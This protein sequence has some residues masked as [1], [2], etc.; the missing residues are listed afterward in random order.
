MHLTQ[1]GVLGMWKRFL[2]LRRPQNSDLRAPYSYDSRSFNNAVGFT[3]MRG[4]ATGC[5]IFYILCLI[6]RTFR[7]ILS[8]CEFNFLWLIFWIFTD[9]VLQYF[10]S[11]STSINKIDIK[12][13]HMIGKM[14]LNKWKHEMKHEHFI[15]PGMCCII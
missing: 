13:A 11:I 10:W 8:Q 14:L 5:S 12:S 15:A 6:R 7:I 3:G 9:F 4:W 1:D 2:N